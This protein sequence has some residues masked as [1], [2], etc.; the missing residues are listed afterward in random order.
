M[1]QR[2]IYPNEP[3]IIPSEWKPSGSDQLYDCSNWSNCLQPSR[4]IQA[5]SSSSQL[6]KKS[7]NIEPAQGLFTRA[8]ESPRPN[9]DLILSLSPGKPLS[10]QTNFQIYYCL[11]FLFCWPAWDQLHIWPWDRIGVL[12]SQL[13]LDVL[14]PGHW[15]GVHHKQGNLQLQEKHA[16]EPSAEGMPGL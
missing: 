5:A 14:E 13:R 10:K 9:A 4:A 15:P 6:E 7:R 1:T 16:M 11:G 12:A 2:K 8:R 3:T